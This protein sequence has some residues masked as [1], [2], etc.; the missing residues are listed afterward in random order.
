M[1]FYVSFSVAFQMG[2]NSKT[3][4]RSGNPGYQIG[5][6][7]LAGNLTSTVL[8]DDSIRYWIQLH[9]PLNKLSHNLA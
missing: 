8:L 2:D 5:Q 9:I 3:F 7:I 4:E 6:P 1:Y